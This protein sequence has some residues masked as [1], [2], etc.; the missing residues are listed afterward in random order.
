MPANLNPHVAGLLSWHGHAAGGV[1]VP[2]QERENPL[3]QVVETALIRRLRALAT[4]I[5]ASSSSRPRWIFLVGGPGNGK[6]ETVQD[7]LVHLDSSLRVGGALEK[8]LRE[9]FARPGLLPRKVEIG[10]GDL[11]SGVAEFTATCGRLVVVQDA[12]ATESAM[13]NAAK[14]LAEDLADLITGSQA[15]PLPVF[16]VC[17]NRGLLSRAMNEAIRIF[18]NNNDVTQLLASVIQASSLGLETLAGRKRCWPL[19][20]DDRF[21]CWPLD[22]ESLLPGGDAASPFDLILDVATS[23]SLWEI[24]GRCADCTSRTLC[25][26]RQS[27][28]WLRETSTRANLS[29][30][31]RHGELARG[32]KWNFRDAFSLVA[33]LLVGQWSDFEPA[34]H[35]C[36]WVHD[37]S[38]AATTN[39]PDAGS[40]LALAMQ[41]FPQ[42]VFRRGHLKHAARAF[43]ALQTLPLHSQPL[44]REIISGLARMGDGASVKPIRD[45]LERDYSRLDPAIYTPQDPGHALRLIEDSFCQSVEQGRSALQLATPCPSEDRLLALLEKAEEEWNLL[46][47]DS[48]TAVLAVCLLR[49]IAGMIA[50]RSTGV[51]LGYH[52][53]DELLREYEAS[54]RDPTR[55]AVVRGALQLLLGDAAPHFNLL[56]ILGQPTAEKQP[57]VSLQGPAPGIRTVPAPVA[58]PSTPGHDTPCIEFTAPAYRVPLTFEFFMA[59][60]LRKE[61]CAGSSLPSSVRAALDRIRHRLAGELCRADDLFLDGR[62][63]IELEGGQRIGV[64]AYGSSP[65]LV[66]D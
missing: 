60:R 38:A 13:G 39:P 61:G 4:E 42:A 32:Q 66:T 43:R 9:K 15:P 36:E 51:R 49:K 58:T 64:P 31:L 5:V 24:A 7:F 45:T 30:L 46:G 6:S 44:T 47:R 48:A 40:I 55:L 12:T 17:A 65:T 29:T 1:H 22:V 34:G 26:F 27:S 2:F 63:S 25:P 37:R 19:E 33:E 10:P 50:K 53:L 35:P 52:A 57:L 14:E 8:A 41:V 62:V 56:E 18:G 21:A 23:T 20:A 3:G 11:A 28:E 16:V 59:L 54:L